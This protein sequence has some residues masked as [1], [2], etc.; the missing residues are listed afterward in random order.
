MSFETYQ[1]SNIFLEEN[2]D[3]YQDIDIKNDVLTVEN[4]TVVVSDSFR[5][6]GVYDRD[7]YLCP[8]SVLLRGKVEKP[9]ASHK[10]INCEKFIDEPVVY[11]GGSYM[12]SHFGHFLVEGL[13]R[14]WALLDKKYNKLKVVIFYE[15]KQ[16]LPSFVRLMLNALGI[17]DENI[18]VIYKTTKFSRVFVP[19]QA[20]NGH[21]YILPIMNKVFD[22]ISSNMPNANYERYDKIYLSRSRMN[23]GRTFGENQV[24]NIFRK[25]GYEVIYPET[26]PLEQ[27]IYLAKNCKEMAGTAGTAL[28]LAMFM[29]S[30]GRVIQIKR[31]ST[32]SDNINTQKLICDLRGLD[33][34]W[35]Y[36]TVETV[37]T[38][39]FTQFPQIIGVTQYL[40][41]FFDD[42]H[43]LYDEKDTEP[44]RIALKKYTRQI[45]KYKA[46][47]IYAKIINTPIKFI[48]LFGLTKHGRKTVREYL[49]K[50]LNAQY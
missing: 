6:S 43:F 35:I 16:K 13:A 25:N 15:T 10:N 21:L 46:H 30:G 50:K 45:L 22:K 8:E 34:V 32:E 17:P 23:D 33:L 2:K 27:Q 28:H 1:P 39:H 7:G 26:L 44:D 5:E 49:R 38:G 42:N 41:D 12:F 47:K 48:S 37:A 19:I 31:N 24:E 11:L 3:N 14:T 36:G 40:T 29:K 9:N 4:G 18:L 20:M